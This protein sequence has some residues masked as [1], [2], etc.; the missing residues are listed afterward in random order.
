MTLSGP[1]HGLAGDAVSTITSTALDQAWTLSRS[2][3]GRWPTPPDPSDC[4]WTPACVPGTVAKTVG[5]DNHLDAHDAY[6]E[7]DW[8]YRSSFSDP[9]GGSRSDS[10]VRLRFDGLATICEVWLNGTRV[11]TSANMFITH[12][13]DVTD[14]VRAENDLVIVFRSLAAA[15]ASRKP[16]PRWKTQLVRHQKLRWFRTTLLGR[17][18]TWTPQIQTVGPWRGISL[19]RLDGPDVIAYRVVPTWTAEGGR[20]KVDVEI[21]AEI[22]SASVTVGD[23]TYELTPIG[24]RA[25]GEVAVRNVEPWWPHTHGPQPLYACRIRL[26]TS[27]TEID[28]DGGHLGFREVAFEETAEGMRFL[29]NGVP[30]FCRGACWTPT[31]LVNLEGDP[32]EVRATLETAVR[33]NANMVRVGGTM[34]YESDWFYR[35]CSELGLMVWQDY[36]FA[37]MDYPTPDPDFAESVDL[38]TAQNASRISK[39]PCVVAFCGGSEVSQQ[40]AMMGTDQANWTSD[41]FEDHLRETTSTYAPGSTYW[42]ST[43][44]GGALPFHPA[45]GLTHYYG[46]GAYKRPIE[47]CRLAQVLFSPECLGF[48]NVPEPLNVRKLQLG[49]TPPTTDPQWK[50]GIPR[51]VGAGWDFEDVR[52]FYLGRLYGEDPTAL[53][54]HNPRRYHELSRTITGRVMATVFDEWRSHGHPCVGA[55]VWFL[56][57]IRPGAGWGILDSDGRPKAV[58]HYLRRAWAPVRVALLDRGLDGLVV[59]VHN[60]SSEILDGQLTIEVFSPSSA[61]T[62]SVSV[63]VSVAPRTSW[64]TNCEEAFGRFLDLTYAYRFGPPE[65]GAVVATLEESDG[66]EAVRAMYWPSLSAPLAPASLEAHLRP[67]GRLEITSS[68]LARGVRIDGAEGQAPDNY[69]D[70]PPGTTARIHVPGC[71]DL[72]VEAENQS[73]GVAASIPQD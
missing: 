14:L 57:D 44:T 20:L 3:P 11:M 58:F 64:Q 29:V 35:T 22:T 43:P 42:P 47:D 25:C 32:A 8:W 54:S 69:L 5:E 72:F 4:E 23:E 9:R 28:L 41:F 17:I 2:D 36:M 67:G 13:L 12:V 62:A 71:A 50:I 40:A 18:P 46:V 53:R 15:F 55:L 60:E 6:D 68:T 70:L 49:Q 24:T 1:T 10:R 38:E 61:R 52:D 56:R 65:V 21:D 27:T 48:S 66:T 19:E 39:F 26:R 30:V 33:A 34:V 16:R 63:D 37:N 45:G 7:Y 59:E 73:H 31:D 51:D